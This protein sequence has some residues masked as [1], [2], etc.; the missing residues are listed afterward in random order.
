MIQTDGPAIVLPSERCRSKLHG[1]VVPMLYG[2]FNNW[3]AQPMIPITKVAEVLDPNPISIQKEMKENGQLREEVNNPNDM[4]R[5]EGQIY[6][7]KHDDY[8]D[9]FL[10]PETWTKAI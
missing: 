7:K 5:R 10:R 2:Q 9:K 6:K 4:D 1:K 3:Q 8:L